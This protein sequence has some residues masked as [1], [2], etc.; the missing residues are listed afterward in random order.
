MDACNVFLTRPLSEVSQA[1]Y[2]NLEDLGSISDS[3]TVLLSDLG[4]V[5]SRL[6]LQFSHL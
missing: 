2:W 4:Q 5:A 6:V 1:C 3:F